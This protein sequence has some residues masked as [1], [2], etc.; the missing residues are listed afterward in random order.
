MVRLRRL[1]VLG[2]GVLALVVAELMLLGWLVGLIGLWRTLLVL[3]AE[4]LLGAALVRLEGAKAWRG[5]TEAIRRGAL[6]GG[7]LADA[8]LILVG[9]LFLIVPG[10]ITDAIGL[11]CLLPFTRPAV[12]ALAGY[13]VVRGAQRAGIDT[14]SFKKRY[15]ADRDAN[16]VIEGETVDGT[17]DPEAVPLVLEPSPDD[18]E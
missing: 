13:F 4:A 6:P 18:A 3:L 2:V 1:P 16:V 14:E 5:M 11:L 10:L 8:V 12:R 17:T 7:H 15:R 9:G